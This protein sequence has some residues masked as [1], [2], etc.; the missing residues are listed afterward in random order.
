MKK[1]SAF[2]GAMVFVFMST[3]V[4]AIDFT[5]TDLGTFSGGSGDRYFAR[6]INDSGQIVGV[7]VPP[8]RPGDRAFL[9]E[10]G[11]MT[12]LGNFGGNTTVASAINNS[13]QVVGYSYDE[14]NQTRLAYLWDN[15]SMTELS[16]LG[17]GTLALGINDSSQ[18]VGYSHD[19]TNS[20]QAL[21]WENSSMTNLGAMDVAEDIN[22]QGKIVG[23]NSTSGLLWD[24]GALT[25]LGQLGIPRS[26][27][28]SNQVVGSGNIAPG[29]THAFLWE[30]DAIIDLGTIGIFINSVAFDINDS[31][32]VVGNLLTGS[33]T[34]RHA[35]LWESGVMTD[36]NDL[37][38]P[39][40]GWEL[41]QAYA[42]NNI[43]QIV[44][45]GLIEGE[46]HAFLLNP[47]PIPS[48]VWLLGSGLIGIMGLRRKFGK[49]NKK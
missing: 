42:I 22:N 43:G 30:N 12:D 47:V 27:N 45:Y 49:E 24:N 16:G 15:G 29:I 10:N 18:I 39:T 6:G 17:G 41:N 9:W 23:Y 38:D 48:A 32:Q 36:L 5:I 21:L 19:A 37:I 1:L 20:H 34:L 46:Q 3:P 7:A 11:T 44:G 13:G 31:G 8:D 4:T 35:F 2:L 33:P 28:G 25:D 26:I 40:S 14:S